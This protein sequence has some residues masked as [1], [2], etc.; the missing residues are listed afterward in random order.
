VICRIFAGTSEIRRGVTAR[1]AR[2]KVAA[3]FDLQR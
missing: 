1:R 2:T 3:L